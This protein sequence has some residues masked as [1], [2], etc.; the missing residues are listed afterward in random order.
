MT[1]LGRIN[2]IDICKK[3]G[4]QIPAAGEHW[5]SI[6]L[7]RRNAL[8]A[9]ATLLFC[10][11][12]SA[13]RASDVNI[14]VAG[15]VIGNGAAFGGQMRDGAAAAVEDL[16]VSGL[17]PATK[18]IST[19]VDDVCDPNH[20]IA[21]T[22]QLTN[23]RV[24]LAVCHFCSSSSIPVYGDVADIVQVLPGSTNR[25]LT[26]RGLEAV[27]R[28]CGCD[29]KQCFVAAE[30]IGSQHNNHPIAVLDDKS[31]AGNDIADAVA[32][33]LQRSDE[34]VNH[35]SY[36]AG[37]K[38]YAALVS[39]L[40]TEG[41]RLAYFG[42]YL[43]E[44]GL[45]VRR[46]SESGAGLIIMANDPLM[47]SNFRVVASTTGNGTLFI[48]MPEPGKNTNAAGIATR[49]NAANMSAEGYMLYAYAAVK[50]PA[51]AVKRVSSFDSARVT[52]ALRSRPT[53]TVI[54]PVRFESN[55]AKRLLVFSFPAGA[56]DMSKT[57]S[58][59][60]RGLT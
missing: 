42:G 45:I 49:L 52:D 53:D 50:A 19:A 24:R 15:P 39:R 51:D 16:N 13:T 37:E 55:E 59:T 11:L 32:A 26:D 5:S 56:S 34:Y 4:R 47:T 22:N 3:V 12:G 57:S 9:S 38:N 14:A 44:V 43:T 2:R 1:S 31:A 41:L 46:A 30:Y 60:D 40:K 8:A 21:V 35:Q 36:V 7:G 10:A 54:G 28:I 6:M 18:L 29:D 20:A 17:L 33:Q 23:E 25:Q 27:F 48:F 58:R